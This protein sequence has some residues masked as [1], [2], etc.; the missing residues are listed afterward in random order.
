[1]KIM[2]RDFTVRE[3]ILL[4]VLVILILAAGY[5]LAVDQP[6]RTS[7]QE[8]KYQQEELNIELQLLKTK[9]AKYMKMQNE[10]NAVGSLGEV[11]V[12]GSYNNAKAELNE[13][14]QI[15]ADAISYDISFE[16]VTR[17]GNLIRRG[18]HLT[19]TTES[20]EK[21]AYMLRSLCT[22]EWRCLVSDVR[23]V[24]D[25]D[26]L[27]EGNVNVGVTAS[28]YETMEGGIADSGLPE[29]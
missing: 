28:F 7:I 16:D 24:S 25:G 29:A 11:G 27:Q 14:N 10:L 26:H 17:E 20:Y 1:M 22:G 23:F 3:K 15:L 5:Y 19:F 13:L 21:A 6:V 2:S 9:A 18:F 12:M 8:A 4:L